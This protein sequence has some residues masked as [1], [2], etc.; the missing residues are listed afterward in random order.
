M[1]RAAPRERVFLIFGAKAFIIGQKKLRA[2]A[3]LLHGSRFRV[4]HGVCEQA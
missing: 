4:I 2:R 1:G 3:R